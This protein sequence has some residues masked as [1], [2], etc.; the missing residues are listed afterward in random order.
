MFMYQV[1]IVCMYAMFLCV[2]IKPP[3]HTPLFLRCSFISCGFQSA[4]I[5]WIHVSCP[6]TEPRQWEALGV[7]WGP[8]CHTC[9]LP[10]PSPLQYRP[11]TL[12]FCMCGQT[13]VTLRYHLTCN[14]I[15]C[16]AHSVHMCTYIILYCVCALYIQYT[17][18]TPHSEYFRFRDPGYCWHSCQIK[19][20]QN[21]GQKYQTKHWTKLPQNDPSWPE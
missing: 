20:L 6:L 13:Y 21:F 5:L 9:A 7:P 11:D 19:N 17:P 10:L 18:C 16:F 4:R 3:T 12:T 8:D 2:A 15:W 1:G 14:V